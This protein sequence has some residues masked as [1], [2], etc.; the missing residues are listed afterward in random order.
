LSAALLVL[1][2]GFPAADLLGRATTWT[3]LV[4]AMKA[5]ADTIARSVWLALAAASVSVG[6]GL[7]L[8]SCRWG[9]ITWLFFFV[10]GVVLGLVWIWA[11]NR[12]G[13][14]W[15]YPSLTGVV[16]AFGLRYCGLGWGAA[17]RA[18]RP[19]KGGLIDVARLDG[20]SWWAT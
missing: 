2:L 18:L 5:G 7:M 14:D 6:L 3:E 15:F 11:F 4:P 16:A 9:S 19:L 12:S 10:P 8:G 1:A 13:L 20:L 17:V